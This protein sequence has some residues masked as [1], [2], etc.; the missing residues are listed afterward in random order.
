MDEKLN[1]GSPETTC[2]LSSFP[3]AWAA[4]EREGSIPLF[5]SGET[6]PAEI[7][8]AL[9]SP[10][11][12]RCGHAGVSPEEPTKMLQG[13]EHFCYGERLGK[14]GEEKALGRPESP[15]Q[16]LKGTIRKMETDILITPAVTG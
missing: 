8:P 4:G 14:P 5:H 3:A 15:F 10:A 13:L 6:S 2:I 12:E 16:Y 7:P 11:Q 9:G 1:I